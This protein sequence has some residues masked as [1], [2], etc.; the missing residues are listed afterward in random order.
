MCR[1]RGVYSDADTTA[2][3][4][5]AQPRTHTQVLFFAQVLPL[6]LSLIAL[7]S[8]SSSPRLAPAASLCKEAAGA[9]FGIE[10]VDAKAREGYTPPHACAPLSCS[11]IGQNRQFACVPATCL[12]ALTRLLVLCCRPLQLPPCAKTAQF[13]AYQPP[14]YPSSLA[15]FFCAADHCS[16]ALARGS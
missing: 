1:P 4:L 10:G 9:S 8:T 15:C 3:R 13:L 6:C 14:A 2:Y 11:L 16:C 5:T 7:A 12:P